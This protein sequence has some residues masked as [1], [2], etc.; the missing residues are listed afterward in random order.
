M[1][2]LV[3]SALRKD[4]CVVRE[5]SSGVELL[6]EIETLVLDLPSL[7]PVD[8][9]LS[10]VCMPG[11][12]GLDLLEDVRGAEVQTPFIL[13]TAFGSDEV[14]E[15]ASALGAGYLEKPFR[16]TALRMAVASRIREARGSES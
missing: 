7:I 2:D 6:I 8:L 5:L 12:S 15:A 13:M 9:I 11:F 14:R 16:L 1:R 3:A 10:D 4:G